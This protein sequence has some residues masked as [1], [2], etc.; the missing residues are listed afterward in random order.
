MFTIS[1]NDKVKGILLLF[2]PNLHYLLV[3]ILASILSACSIVTAPPIMT[4]EKFDTRQNQQGLTEFVYGVSWRHTSQESIIG[5]QPESKLAHSRELKN[6]SGN[7][8]QAKIQNFDIQA[9]NQTK[10]E[11]EDKAAQA[12][13]KKL[14]QQ[15]TCSLTYE[16]TKVIWKADSIRLFGHCK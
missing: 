11:L 7:T 16:I 1:L 15:Q 8:Q 3:S 2:K 9:N 13:K 12:L 10:L 14:V 4:N 5:A 6:R